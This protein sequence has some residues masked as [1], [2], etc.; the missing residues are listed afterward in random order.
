MPYAYCSSEKCSHNEYFAKDE[1]GAPKFCGKCG[2]PM[3]S[4]CP[5]CK[6]P[7]EAMDYSFCPECG[8][9]YKQ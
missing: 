5:T 4:G 6:H 1:K 3:I 2:S 8:K 7:R 9:P